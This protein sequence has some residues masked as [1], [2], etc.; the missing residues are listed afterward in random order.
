MCHPLCIQ[1]GRSGKGDDPFAA[2]VAKV[3]EEI[4]G[5]RLDLGPQA[6]RRARER[7]ARAHG[8]GRV[9][10]LDKVAVTA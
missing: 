3:Y 4:T 10:P 6:D 2:Q 7:H 9:F 8:H 1:R 5:P